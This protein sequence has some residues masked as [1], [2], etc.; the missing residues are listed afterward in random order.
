MIEQLIE[1]YGERYRD[2]ITH[3]VE[4]YKKY[5]EHMLNDTLN[6]AID[7]IRRNKTSDIT[8]VSSSIRRDIINNLLRERK[9]D[10]WVKE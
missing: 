1:K 8:I 6:Y 3:L 7:S 2:L 4:Q 9:L 10:N 5:D